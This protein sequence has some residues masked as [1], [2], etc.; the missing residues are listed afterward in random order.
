MCLLIGPTPFAKAYI[1]SEVREILPK[2]TDVQNLLRW[3]QEI[4]K[5]VKIYIQKGKK[6]SIATYAFQ[7]QRLS[8]GKPFWLLVT[9]FEFSHAKITEIKAEG[10][11]VALHNKER[12]TEFQGGNLWWIKRKGRNKEAGRCQKLGFSA[13]WPLSGAPK[14]PA[15]LITTF[16]NAFCECFLCSW[17]KP[18]R[19]WLSI[20]KLT[21]WENRGKGGR[22]D[23]ENRSQTFISKESAE[24]WGNFGLLQGKKQGIKLILSRS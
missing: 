5:D 20:L 22:D 7:R 6:I 13:M 15:K 2:N 19:D 21:G 3:I 11:Q 10:C 9:F 17:W 4:W 14:S 23:P 24:S 12:R 16:T 1:C 18:G 8:N